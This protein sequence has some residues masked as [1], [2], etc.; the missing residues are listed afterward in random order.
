MKCPHGYA[1][2]DHPAACV[3]CGNEPAC[4]AALYQA[5]DEHDLSRRAEVKTNKKSKQTYLLY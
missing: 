5:S 2:M 4:R 1:W 3:Y